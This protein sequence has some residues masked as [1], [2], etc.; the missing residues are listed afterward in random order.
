MLFNFNLKHFKQ[1]LLKKLIHRSERK[2]NNTTE[3]GEKNATHAHT[4][5]LPGM[6]C[7]CTKQSYHTRMPFPKRPLLHAENFKLCIKCISNF[8]WWKQKH[9]TRFFF[10]SL[11]PSRSLSC[12][13]K[14]NHST[15]G[16]ALI[17]LTLHKIQVE[18]KV[19]VDKKKEEKK[20]THTQEKKRKF[21]LAIIS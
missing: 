1:Q 15:A 9:W 6:L 7:C 4:Q 2:S 3:N 11:S 8:A 16:C 12:L 13:S 21:D 19:K 20:N 5:I 17:N 18:V 14:V 10:I